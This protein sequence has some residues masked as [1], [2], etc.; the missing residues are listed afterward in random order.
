MSPYIYASILTFCFLCCVSHAFTFNKIHC[1]YIDNFLRMSQKAFFFFSLK[2]YR[3]FRLS[4]CNHYESARHNKLVQTEF[5]S[6]AYYIQSG[7]RNLEYIIYKEGLGNFV[8]QGHMKCNL[9]VPQQQFMLKNLQTW[10][11]RRAQLDM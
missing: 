4:D 1:N 9:P 10:L 11:K 5:L 2:H 7:R 6:L 8:C 3:N